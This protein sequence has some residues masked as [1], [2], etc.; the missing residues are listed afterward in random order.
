MFSTVAPLAAVMS[1]TSSGAWAMTG[2][3]PAASTTLA[4]SLAETMLLIQWT[5]GL[6]ARTSSRRVKSGMGFTPLK[7]D[8]P[9]G[10]VL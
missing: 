9:W 7:M 1:A 10:P 3:A 4:Q 6:R 8:V 5:R 2:P